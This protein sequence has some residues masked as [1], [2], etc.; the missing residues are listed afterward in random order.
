MTIF[1]LLSFPLGKAKFNFFTAKFVL[2]VC[3]L[4]E[5][6]Q[7]SQR[8]ISHGSFFFR[9]GTSL[10]HIL[11]RK[12]KYGFMLLFIYLTPRRLFDLCPPLLQRRGGGVGKRGF[13]HLKHPNLISLE[14][15]ELK[16]G[17]ASLIK[18]FPLPLAREGG[19]GDRLPNNLNSG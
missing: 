11:E 13:T 8:F 14:R 18:P 2:L 15:G 19:Q 6:F 9:H 7:V 12:A 16:R 10:Y 5:G 4:N 3:I 1:S 17:E